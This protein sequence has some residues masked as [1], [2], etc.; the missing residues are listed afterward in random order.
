MAIVGA[1][2]GAS[3]SANAADAPPPPA[4]A[5]VGPTSGIEGRSARLVEP[6]QAPPSEP[7]ERN[8]WAHAGGRFEGGLRTA[9]SVPLGKVGRGK[10]GGSETRNLGSLTPW[11]TPIWL[12]LSYRLNASTS[13]G[14]YVQ[15]GFGGTGDACDGECTFA[16]LHLGAQG[17][18]R[19]APGSDL[20]PWLSV[21]V[22]Y[23]S[24]TFRTLRILTLEEGAVAQP[25]QAELRLSERVGGPELVLQGGLDFAVGSALKVGPYAYG[26][27]GLYVRDGIKCSLAQV[28]CAADTDIEGSG[29]HS[30]IGLGLRGSYNP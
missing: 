28:Q 18:Y 2:A 5:A 27:L 8:S 16:D 1:I 3:G 7:D 15:F 26:T 25:S 22:G 11:R 20:D 12:D 21:G 10:E 6:T 14:A 9:I 13:L 19:L 4:N 24:L 17:T 23:E 29:F 30:W